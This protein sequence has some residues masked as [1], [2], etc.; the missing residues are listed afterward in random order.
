L[1]LFFSPY[2]TQKQGR[3]VDRPCFFVQI[4]AVYGVLIP[5]MSQGQHSNVGTLCFALGFSVMMALDVALG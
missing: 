5:E 4:E 2:Q 3:S 1:S